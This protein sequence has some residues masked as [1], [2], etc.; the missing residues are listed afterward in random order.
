MMT[1]RYNLRDPMKDARRLTMRLSVCLW[2]ALAGAAWG[3]AADIWT[4]PATE[5]ARQ[6]SALTGPGAISLSVRNNSS[7]AASEV[8]VIR[9]RLQ[10]ALGALG[11]TIRNQAAADAA[12]TV[13]VTLSQTAQQGLWVAEVQQGPETRVAMV[14]A[15]NPAPPVEVEGTPVLLRRALL[16]SQAAPMLDVGLFA[17]PGDAAGEGHLVV[18]SPESIAIYYRDQKA[19]GGWMKDQSF[20][21][22][23]GRAYPRDVRGRLQLDAARYSRL[24]F[25]ELSA[26]RQSGLRVEGLRFRVRIVMI[27]GRSVRARRSITPAGIF[28]QE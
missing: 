26:R 27:P 15:A 18:L 6:I 16:F 9:Q 22:A 2:L 7:I 5:L 20:E 19:D 13:Q 14:T 28:S 21:I 24:I 17:P 25:R 12:T 8:P 1:A 3:Q 4:A 23:H 11:V 10:V